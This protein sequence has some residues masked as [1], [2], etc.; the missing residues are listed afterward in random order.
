M[1]EG[2]GEGVKKFL[3]PTFNLPHKGGGGNSWGIGL[4]RDGRE[5]FQILFGK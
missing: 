3:P 4:V 1:G 5:K 2:R